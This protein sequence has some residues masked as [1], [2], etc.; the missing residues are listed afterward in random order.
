[1]EVTIIASKGAP[2]PAGMIATKEAWIT[3]IFN[4]RIVVDQGEVIAKF[5]LHGESRTYFR[6]DA[7]LRENDNYLSVQNLTK[8]TGPIRIHAFGCATLLS[9]NWKV[10]HVDGEE[11]H[12][13]FDS[14]T[15]IENLKPG[16]TVIWNLDNL[17]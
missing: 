9:K 15:N 16:S 12:N 10:A 13:I 11:I 5:S 17:I 6:F 1:M 4:D 2:T 14:W 3:V 7:E 8:S